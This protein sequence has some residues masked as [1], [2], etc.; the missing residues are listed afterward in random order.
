M[1]IKVTGLS[2]QY[3]KSQGHTDVGEN[4][5]TY[6]C[7]IKE[8]IQSNKPVPPEVLAEYKQLKGGK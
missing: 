2:K 8:A 5:R 7:E 6:W 1:S 3:R 4:N